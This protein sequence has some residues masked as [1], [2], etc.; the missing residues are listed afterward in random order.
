M[1]QK[2]FRQLL[3]NKAEF[4]VFQKRKSLQKSR[5]IEEHIILQ[6]R[7]PNQIITFFFLTGMIYFVKLKQISCNETRLLK[8]LKNLFIA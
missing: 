8:Q 2:K 1:V 5:Q 7:A 6:Q 4:N 3:L